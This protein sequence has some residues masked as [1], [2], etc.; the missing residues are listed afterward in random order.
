ME[1][2][3]ALPAGTRPQGR[4]ETLCKAYISHLA[5]DHLEIA[6]DQV[7]AAKPAATAA[8]TWISDRNQM[9]GWM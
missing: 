1:V 6:Q 9:D 7:M 8:Q 4:P 5:L 2:F 3:Q